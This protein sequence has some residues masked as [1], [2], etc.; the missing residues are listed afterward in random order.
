MSIELTKLSADEFSRI[1]S[2]E[3]TPAMAA[4][5]LRGEHI[6]PR[7]FGDILRGLYGADDIQFRLTAAFSVESDSAAA[8]RK[9]YNWL[10][11]KNVPSNRE[12]IFRIAFALDLSEPQANYLLGFCTNYG[13]HYRDGHDED[14]AWFLRTGGAYADARTFYESLPPVPAVTS[15]TNTDRVTQ[16]LKSTFLLVQNE[17]D[18]RR[19]YQDNLEKFGQLHLRAFTYFDRYMAQL[20]HPV[21]AWEDTAEE[22]YSLEAVMEM[23]FQMQMPSSRSRAGYSVTQKLV[24]TNW[25]NATTLKDIYA[26]R[27][28]VPRKLL[29]LLYIITENVID[30]NY[31]ELDEDYASD[32]ERIEDHW[33]TINAI[34]ADCG[35]PPLDLRNASDWLMMYAVT[36]NDETMSEKLEHVI[37]YMFRDVE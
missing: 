7:D 20:I 30:Q 15:E 26:R 8:G 24:K 32:E 12:D 35:M 36:A 33:W 9:V 1:Q 37:A 29:L 25:P 34:L 16:Q 31:S 17:E 5:Y 23:Y 18:L 27:K 28:D 21:S 14:Y 11:G 6:I 2:G 4:E 10:S 19:C 13:I 3:M 22:T